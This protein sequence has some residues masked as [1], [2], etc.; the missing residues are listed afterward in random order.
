MK[1]AGLNDPRV[2]SKCHTVYYGL[3]CHICPVP[4]NKKEIANYHRG[5]SLAFIL[6]LVGIILF[7]GG[8]A[9]PEGTAD[10]VYDLKQLKPDG[11]HVVIANPQKGS[12]W[13]MV[14]GIFVFATGWKMNK[15][16]N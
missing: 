3:H 15:S 12:G 6:C 2:C 10:Y 8:M 13:L 16:R 14:I 5:Q 4:A 7:I 9:G 11:S 1:S